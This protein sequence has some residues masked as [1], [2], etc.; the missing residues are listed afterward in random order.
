MKRPRV[1]HPVLFAVA[2]VLFL[3]SHNVEELPGSVI[4]GP[5]ALILAVSLALWGLLSRATRNPVKAG[6]TVTLLLVWFFTYGHLYSS[7][8]ASFAWTMGMPMR[9]RYLIPL[10]T[11]LFAVCL[12]LVWRTKRDLHGLTGALNAVGAVP[13]AM[14]VGQVILFQIGGRAHLPTAM[15]S[16]TLP[17]PPVTAPAANAPPDIYY[18][19]LDAYANQNVLERAFSYSNR[20]FLDGLKRRGFYVAE[21]SRSNYAMTITSMASSLN[22]D[23]LD[24]PAQKAG[25]ESRDLLPLKQMIRENQVAKLLRARGYAYVDL[26]SPT[27]LALNDFRHTLLRTTI[28]C[29][30][31]ELGYFRNRTLALFD[32]LTTLPG[33]RHPI[34]VYAHVICPHPPYVF[35][36]NGEQRDDPGLQLAATSGAQQKGRYLDQV[37]YVS[38]RALEVIDVILARSQ[39]PPVIILQSDHGPAVNGNLMAP[40]DVLYRERMPIL[41]AYLLP[42]GRE[43]KPY[44]SISPVNTFRLIFNRYFGADYPLLT[45][46]S[47]FSTYKKPYDFVDVT[48]TTIAAISDAATK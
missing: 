17:P 33:R 43:A 40:N 32:Q 46:R 26:N 13:V 15:A 5:T 21:K 24:G 37:R 4:A 38:K 11:V 18:I 44:A 34:F 42:G 9:H 47:Y 7:L 22:M 16:G 12:L 3:Y 27:D 10:W 41:N 8:S 28:L 20:E 14:A 25:R 29:Y 6:L 36:P 48:D 35:G 31:E 19:I 1:I 45:D 30:Q 2:P 39:Q 23:Y